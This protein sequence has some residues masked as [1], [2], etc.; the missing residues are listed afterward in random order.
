[1]DIGNRSSV[2]S[3]PP[4]GYLGVCRYNNK[5]L[6]APASCPGM[7]INVNFIMLSS[8]VLFPDPSVTLTVLSDTSEIHAMEIGL[9]KVSATDYLL[10][11]SF[12]ACLTFIISLMHRCGDADIHHVRSSL[13]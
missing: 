6:C 11:R 8:T 2:E 12:S 5:R 13:T 1:M 3:L 10:L 4:N 9:S 7:V